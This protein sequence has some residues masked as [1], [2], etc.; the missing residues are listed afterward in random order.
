MPI[1][2][3]M[4]EP[5]AS[6]C[7]ICINAEWERRHTHTYP[8]ALQTAVCGCVVS[9]LLVSVRLRVLGCADHARQTR[10]NVDTRIPLHMCLPTH[11]RVHLCGCVGIRR[12]VFSLCVGYYGS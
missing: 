1:A 7:T 6:K 2:A 11:A 8:F 3:H 9:L 5:T 12:G 10:M 4:W